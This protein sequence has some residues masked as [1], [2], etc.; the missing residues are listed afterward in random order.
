[1][2]IVSATRLFTF[3]RIYQASGK[4]MNPDVIRLFYGLLQ[5]FKPLQTSCGDEEIMTLRC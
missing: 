1:M 3:T 2:P 5:R 4:S